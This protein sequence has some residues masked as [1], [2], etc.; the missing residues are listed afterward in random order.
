VKIFADVSQAI[1]D[2]LLLFTCVAIMLLT[3]VAMW[4][5]DEET[6]R[7]LKEKLND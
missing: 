7:K 5:A 2:T 1:R 3:S 4:L 6:V